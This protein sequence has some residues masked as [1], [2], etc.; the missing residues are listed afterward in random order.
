MK[1]IIPIALLL[2]GLLVVAGVYFFVIRDG[3]EE[4]IGEEE[5]ALIEVALQDKP[6]ASLTPRSDGHWLDMKI[7]KLGEF[8]AES[9]DYELL[10][11]LSD[12]RTQ[13]VPGSII[14]DGKKLIEREL[15]LGSESSGK[16]RYDE[17]VESGTFTLRF[18][19]KKGKLLVKFTSEFN[20]QNTKDAEYKSG[21]GKFTYKLLDKVG[22]REGYVVT[23]ETF[24]VPKGSPK[25]PTSEPYGVFSSAVSGFAGTVE[26]GSGTVNRW[27]DN[28]WEELK[29]NSSEGFGIFVLTSE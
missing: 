24:G 17:G 21:D 4:T 9:V 25:D 6:V 3:D 16:F 18:R 22:S 8:K 2:V 12:G 23:M 5:T 15:L 14:L 29:S 26:M 7:D 19:N 13:G 1:K 28:N 10:Y 11:K 27:W 20:L